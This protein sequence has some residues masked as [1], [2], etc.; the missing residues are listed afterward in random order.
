MGTM[1]VISGTPV[2]EK[3]PPAS[4]RNF[5][6]A[7]GQHLGAGMTGG[8]S[9]L[10]TIAMLYFEDNKYA[11]PV[12]AC[13]A[14]AAAGFAAFRIWKPE[15]EKVCELE[16][17][18]RQKIEL[19]FDRSDSRCFHLFQGGQHAHLIVYNGSEFGVPQCQVML[20]SV[21]L[22]DANGKFKRVEKYRAALTL[23]WSGFNDYR[24][25]APITLPPGEHLV[26]LVWAAPNHI[27]SEGAPFWI[28]VSSDHRQFSFFG[29]LGR[30]RLT[31]RASS[32]DTA[33]N[34]LQLLVDWNGKAAEMDVRNGTAQVIVFD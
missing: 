4:V 31:V 7:F 5:L 20:E 17:R 22:A 6:K 25:Y 13:L 26:D 32:P 2:K 29:K 24:K 21:E 14:I 28:N 12:F 34:E 11:Q 1:R 18:L 27:T 8:L 33:S 19:R 3:T 15:R 16:E 9:L 30:Y 10:S 23:A